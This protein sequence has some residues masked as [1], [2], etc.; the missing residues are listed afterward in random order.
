MRLLSRIEACTLSSS[1]GNI[2]VRGYMVLEY[3]ELIY[4][5]TLG[6]LQINMYYKSTFLKVI[7]K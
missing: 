5:N 3:F 7:K 2:T 4:N 6:R 1:Y